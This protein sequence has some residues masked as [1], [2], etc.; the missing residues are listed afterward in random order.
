[1]NL[2]EALEPIKDEIFE[3]V[4]DRH[5]SLKA[6]G[7]HSGEPMTHAQREFIRL[8]SVDLSMDLEPL[9]DEAL[10]QYEADESVKRWRAEAEA[11]INFNAAMDGE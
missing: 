3:K 8:D 6:L 10:S 4:M 7:L 11:E 9:I 2:S 5:F 1:M